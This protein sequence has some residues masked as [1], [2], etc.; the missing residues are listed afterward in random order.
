[1]E[2]ALADSKGD[3]IN[4]MHGLMEYVYWGCCSVCKERE[5]LVEEGL[6]LCVQD[7]HLTSHG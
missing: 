3:V 1:M 7:R 6:L 4:F 2:K 5:V